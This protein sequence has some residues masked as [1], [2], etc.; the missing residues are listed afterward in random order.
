[1]SRGKRGP[2]IV[3]GRACVKCGA[4]DWRY[5]GKAY[6][7]KACNRRW[8]VAAGRAQRVQDPARTLYLLAKQR[9]GKRGVPFHITEADVRA[10]WPAD[11]RCPALGLVLRTHRG[12]PKASSPSLDRLNNAWGYEPGNI[13]VLSHLANRAKNSLRAQDLRRL[14]AWMRAQGLD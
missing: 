3:R 6:N 8:A 9:A 11:G 7:C 5:D 13:V 14:A 4:D 12:S 1:M 10:A 2:G